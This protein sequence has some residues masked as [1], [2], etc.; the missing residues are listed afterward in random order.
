MAKPIR[1]LNREATIPRGRTHKDN[2][3][4]IFGHNYPSGRVHRGHISYRYCLALFSKA[5]PD[6]AQSNLPWHSTDFLTYRTSDPAL[7]QTSGYSDII[8]YYFIVSKKKRAPCAYKLS[9]NNVT[10]Y[11]RT[12]LRRKCAPRIY[13]LI[14]TIWYAIADIYCPK[15]KWP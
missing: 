2:I 9:H 12:P 5:G 13:C 14:R 11:E 1:L 3:L 8:I 15:E 7:P 6:P 4:G 10:R